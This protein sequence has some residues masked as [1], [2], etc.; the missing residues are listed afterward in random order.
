MLVV[1]GPNSLFWLAIVFLVAWGSCSPL[2]HRLEFED[3][4]ADENGEPVADMGSAHEVVTLEQSEGRTRM[5]IVPAFAN[6]EQREQWAAMGVEE[7]MREAMGQI[8]ALLAEDV[9]A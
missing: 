7:G 1:L 4:F 5:T 9:G 6:V 2:S 8:D 3:R